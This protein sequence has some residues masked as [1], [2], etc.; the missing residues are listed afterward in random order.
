MGRVVRIFVNPS[1][2]ALSGDTL[3]F[4]YSDYMM[5]NFG[6]AETVSLKRMLSGNEVKPFQYALHKNRNGVELSMATPGTYAIEIATMQGVRVGNIRKEGP[7]GMALTREA[8]GTGVF[9]LRIRNQAG[10]ELSEK[11]SML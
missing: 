7:F 5:T 1:V 10:F 3:W 6:P 2:K 4:K 9:M 11:I 8:L